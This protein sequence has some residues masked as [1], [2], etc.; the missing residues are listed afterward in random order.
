MQQ[1]PPAGDII[2]WNGMLR[3]AGSGRKM[4]F[5][6]GEVYRTRPAAVAV[7]RGMSP[8]C[9]LLPRP[10]WASLPFSEGHQGLPVSLIFPT[11]AALL[12]AG[13]GWPRPRCG[14]AVRGCSKLFR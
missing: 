11:F 4:P 14:A 6:A 7:R 9:L 1:R 10:P 13:V 8:S 12:M 5:R 3:P 2:C